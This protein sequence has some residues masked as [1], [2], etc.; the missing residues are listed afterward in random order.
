LMVINDDTKIIPGHG[1]PS[2]KK[3]LETYVAMLEDIR[4]NIQAAIDS[5]ASLEDVKGNNSL[6][7]AYDEVYGG[8]FINPERLRETFYTSLKGK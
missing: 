2:N 1:R 3:E 6:T 8:G 5:D 4:G 7:K